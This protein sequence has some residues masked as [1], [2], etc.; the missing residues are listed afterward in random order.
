MMLSVLHCVLS[1][2]WGVRAVIARQKGLY[3]FIFYADILQTQRN[4][5]SLLG[6]QFEKA[7]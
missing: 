4:F 7:S 6:V 2:L 5:L 3:Y 1:N